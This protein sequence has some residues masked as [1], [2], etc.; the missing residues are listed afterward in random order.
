MMEQGQLLPP[1]SFSYSP[2]PSN[3]KKMLEFIPQ[4]NDQIPCLSLGEPYP[5]HNYLPTAFQLSPS[6]NY[7]TKM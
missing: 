2:L 4:A 1:S 7:K 6:K 5:D 3:E